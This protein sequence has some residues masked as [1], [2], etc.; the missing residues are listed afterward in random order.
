MCVKVTVNIDVRTEDFEMVYEF[1][2]S[3][4]AR[5]IDSGRYEDQPM[6]SY[7]HCNDMNLSTMS[8][9][10]LFN[11]WEMPFQWIEVEYERTC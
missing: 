2:Q 7:I 11:D 4:G 6:F 5:I 3:Y 10:E 8:I 9:K 1:L